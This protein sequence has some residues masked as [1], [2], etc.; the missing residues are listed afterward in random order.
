MADKTCVNFDIRRKTTRDARTMKTKR[1]M[2]GG[3]RIR[4]KRKLNQKRGKYDKKLKKTK[5]KYF[6][7]RSIVRELDKKVK[8]HSFLSESTNKN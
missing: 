6:L 5:E 3:E 2:R 8:V 4:R 7:Y 1:F